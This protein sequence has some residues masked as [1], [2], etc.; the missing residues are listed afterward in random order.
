MAG[1]IGLGVDIAVL[2]ILEPSMGWYLARVFSFLAAATTTWLFNSRITFK[3]APNSHAVTSW[4]QQYLHYLT[5]MLVGGIV[6]Y[7][8]YAAVVHWVHIDG[9]A[10][11]GVALGSC[12]GMT[13]NFLS[14]RHLVFRSAPSK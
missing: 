10:L 3:L 6:N 7:T 11:L 4:V 8:V 2:Y 14:A 5:T 9:A 12:S 13:L 1:V